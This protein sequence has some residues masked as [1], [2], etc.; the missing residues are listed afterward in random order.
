M[1]FCA[2]AGLG[3]GRSWACAELCWAWARHEVTIGWAAQG[4][5]FVGLGKVLAGH[6]LEST[7]HILGSALPRLCVGWAMHE[8]GWEWAGECF[9]LGMSRDGTG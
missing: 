5:A 3:M 8:L 2:C 1:L 7:G 9:V 6:A 4:R